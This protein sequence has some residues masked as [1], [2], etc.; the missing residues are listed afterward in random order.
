[1]RLIW[2]GVG[3]LHRRIA[4]LLLAHAASHPGTA[5][6]APRI[7]L[8]LQ[9]HV[10]NPLARRLAPYLPGEAVIE[11]VGR[12]SGRPR[13]TPVGGRLEGRTFWIVSEFGRQSQYVRNIDQDPNV[14]LQL[15]GRWL[16][17]AAT[18]VDSDDP[19]LRLKRLPWLNSIVVRAVGTD[20]LTVRVDLDGDR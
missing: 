9:R 5:R 20:L 1:M 3:L 6:P 7:V 2:S 15:S 16:T 10:A 11:T 14:R 4:P 13:R 18:I 17:G 19:R 12:R 8:W